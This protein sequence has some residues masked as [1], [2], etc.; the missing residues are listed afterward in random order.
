MSWKAMS[1]SDSLDDLYAPSPMV[2]SLKMKIVERD[3]NIK[4]I[5][6]EFLHKPKGTTFG[7]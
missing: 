2:E 3:E 4:Y 6:N 7:M 1:L 5:N